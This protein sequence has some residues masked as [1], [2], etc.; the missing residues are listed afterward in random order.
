MSLSDLPNDRISLLVGGP[1]SGTTWL[2]KIFDSHPDVLYRHEP[3]IVLRQTDLNRNFSPDEIAPFLPA[4]GDYL[5]QLL[6]VR[7]IKSAGSLPTF[8]KSYN[9]ALAHRARQAMVMAI[10]IAAKLNIAAATVQALSVPD[11]IDAEYAARLHLVMKS[12]SS[13]GRARLFA[14]ALPGCKIV[15]IVRDPC[16]QIASTTRGVALGKLERPV[17]F[18]EILGTAQADRYGLTQEKLHAMPKMAQLAWHWTVSNEKTMDDLADLPN[19]TLI[20]Y[21]D[22]CLEPMAKARELFAF[23]GLD[24]S[25]QTEAFVTESS[26]SNAPDRY[27]Q[28][29]KNTNES[30]NKW[31]NQLSGDDAATILS[32]VR[33]TRMWTLCKE[34]DA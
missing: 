22:L 19:A 5:R 10:K 20:R 26:T 2:A 8:N 3:D 13:R 27:F 6:G 15:F 24:W 34:Y 11:F 9:G 32:V 12:V 29:Y 17:P 1:R 21:Q 7:T 14:E 33:Q 31:R 16:G 28:V 18:D 25:A 30:L 23:T 4:A